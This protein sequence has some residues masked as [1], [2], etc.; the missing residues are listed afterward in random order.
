METGYFQV[1][2]QSDQAGWDNSVAV[3][4]EMRRLRE[5]NIRNFLFCFKTKEMQRGYKLVPEKMFSGIKSDFSRV[6]LDFESR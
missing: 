3:V 1:F 5:L 2:L 4:V 6:L